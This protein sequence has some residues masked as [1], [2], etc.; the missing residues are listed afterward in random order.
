MT[1]ASLSFA[2]APTRL[3]LT[4]RGRAV[5]ATL[6]VAPLLAAGVA[7]GFNA[8]PAVAGDA[9]APS[10]ELNTVTILDG[11]SLWSVAEDIAP[12]HDPRDVIADIVKLNGLDSA[13]VP[14]GATLAVPSY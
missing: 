6:A 11:Q 13:N 3:R 8:S 1:A 7:F 10:A 14:S 9:S 5:F 2:P 4:R 12:G